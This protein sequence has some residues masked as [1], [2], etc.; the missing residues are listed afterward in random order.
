MH[1]LPF[2]NEEDDFIVPST[3]ALFSID[4]SARASPPPDCGAPGEEVL[5][6]VILDGGDVLADITNTVTAPLQLANGAPKG[7]KP[8]VVEMLDGSVQ[9]KGGMVGFDL[10]IVMNRT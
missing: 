3:S 2:R 5:H 1:V 10:K 9:L 8:T 4:A 6:E 7:L